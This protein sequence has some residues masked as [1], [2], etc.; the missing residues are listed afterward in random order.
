MCPP[1]VSRVSSGCNSMLCSL[2]AA[3]LHG[4][5]PSHEWSFCVDYWFRQHEV[6]LQWTILTRKKWHSNS[7]KWAGHLRKQQ[8]SIYRAGVEQAVCSHGR[9]I[10]FLW[11]VQGSYTQG[12]YVWLLYL[13]TKPIWSFVHPFKKLKFHISFTFGMQKLLHDA[14]QVVAFF[15]AN[16]SLMRFQLLNIH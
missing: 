15:K 14:C 6:L 9:C 1:K 12:S 11:V 5:S 2:T 7:L 4:R 13:I 16:V 3:N 10:F 8:A